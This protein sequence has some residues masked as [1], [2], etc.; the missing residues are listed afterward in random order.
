[1]K[2][3]PKSEKYDV[4]WIEQ[5][6][7]G[8]NPLWLLEDLCGHLNLH[9]DMKV[10]DMGCGKGI[11]SVFLAKEYGV[12]VFANDLWISATDNLRRFEEAGVVDKVFPIHAEAHALPY[13]DGFFDVAISIDSYNY[14]GTSESYFPEVFSKLVKPGGQFGIVVPGFRRE[15]EKGYPETLAKLWVPELFT[16]HSNKWW[17]TLWEKTG[18]CEIL[19]CYDIDDPK[20]LWQP[21]ADWAVRNFDKEF[22]DAGGGGDFDA[23]LLEADT[24]NDLALIAL[25]AK[26]SQTK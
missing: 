4:D 22:G 25:V 20:A 11:T 26:K 14:Y 19:S 17:R 3:Y 21:W 16:L 10:L 1:M 8:P 7:M 9:P 5:N 2:R 6:W 18:L 12:T 23:K 15:F 24:D 13:A